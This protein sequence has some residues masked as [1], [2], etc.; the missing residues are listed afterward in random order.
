MI[1]ILFYM[2][3]NKFLN[4]RKKLVAKIITGLKEDRR[5]LLIFSSGSI[6]GGLVTKFSDIDLWIV[7]SEESGINQFKLEISNIF[8]EFS[9]LIGVYKCTEHHYFVICSSG[10]QIDL[11]LTTAAQYFSIMKVSENK[12][13]FDRN[14]FIKKDR[15]SLNNRKDFV[16]EKILIGCTTLERG[17]NKFIKKDYFVAT[18]FIESVRNGAILPLLSLIGKEKFVNMVTFN[19]NNLTSEIKLLFEESFP[20][21]T[22]DG[23]LQAIVAEFKLLLIIK[24]KLK[25]EKFDFNFNRISKFLKINKSLK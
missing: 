10:I 5:I 21:P 14:H 11:N 7:L 1:D 4:V 25:I 19:I 24:D 12:V 16:E 22:K 3:Q 17:I 15:Q 20:V 8:S 18:R 13:L 2:N 9:K 23:C 6:N